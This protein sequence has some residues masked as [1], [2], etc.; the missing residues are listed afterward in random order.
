LIILVFINFSFLSI[1]I[2]HISVSKCAVSNLFFFLSCNQLCYFTLFSL[3]LPFSNHCLFSSF[4]FFL[5]IFIALASTIISSEWIFKTALAFLLTREQKKHSKQ[6]QIFVTCKSS[7]C[8]YVRDSETN[9]RSV[10]IQ[11]KCLVP[12][13]VFPEMKLFGLIPNSLHSFICERFIHSPDRSAYFAAS[14]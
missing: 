10:R 13:H 2:L 1:F 12:I 8:S 3:L 7:C 9:E 6:K 14:K 11:Y 4:M 5:N